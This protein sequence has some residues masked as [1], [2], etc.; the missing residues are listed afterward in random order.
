MGFTTCRYIALKLYQH[1]TP[2]ASV[3][4]MLCG[5]KRS[6]IFFVWLTLVG[7]DRKQIPWQQLSKERDNLN[8]RGTNFTHLIGKHTHS[9][10]SIVQLQN[11]YAIGLIRS[12]QR[13]NFHRN[14]QSKNALFQQPIHIAISSLVRVELNLKLTAQTGRE[15]KIF[16]FDSTNCVIKTVKIF[17]F[18]P[19]AIHIEQF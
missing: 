13:N 4:S 2:I 9:I 3:L 1:R 16:P 14:R 19:I 17:K 15:A 8:L 12:T 5:A 7:Q 6:Q 10:G 11:Y 18:K